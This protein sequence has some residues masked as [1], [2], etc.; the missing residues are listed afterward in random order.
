MLSEIVTP[1]VGVVP[2]VMESAGQKLTRFPDMAVVKFG[3]Q[4][5]VSWAQARV[6][7]PK[8]SAVAANGSAGHIDAPRNMPIHQFGEPPAKTSK[9]AFISRR[10]ANMSRLLMGSIGESPLTV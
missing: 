7:P 1:H 5:V 3:L 2:E 4:E 8:K 9:R 10:V 6:R